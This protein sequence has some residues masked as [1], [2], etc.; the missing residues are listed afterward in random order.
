[1]GVCVFV[2]ELHDP[3]DEADDALDKAQE[4]DGHHIAILSSCL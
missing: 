2:E 1:M 3:V 4:Y